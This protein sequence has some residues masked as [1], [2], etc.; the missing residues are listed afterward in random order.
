MPV[1][2]T[3]DWVGS[4]ALLQGASNPACNAVAVTPSDTD[5]LAKASRAL[6]IGTAGTLSVTT[7]GDKLNA[8]AHVNLTVPAGVLPLRVTRV[9]ST[10]TAA[11]GITALW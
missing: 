11:T 6:V 10:N 9:W 3:D 4:P 7:L 8:A 5:D 1:T 2:Y